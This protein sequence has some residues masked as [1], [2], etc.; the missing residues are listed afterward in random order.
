MS[1]KPVNLETLNDN[2]VGMEKLALALGGPVPHV[3]LVENFSVPCSSGPINVRCYKPNTDLPLPVLIYFHGGGYIRG[4]LDSHHDLCARLAAYGDFAVLSVDYRLAPENKFPAAIDDSIAVFKWVQSHGAEYGFMQDKIAVG[5]DSSGGCLAIVTA[6]EAK[7]QQLPL[8]VFQL[9]FYPTTTAYF[10][11]RSHKL[12]SKG[13]F[14]S[15]ERM[16]NYRDL[17][18]NSVAE[19]DDYRASPLLNPDLANLPSAL[20][21][22]A[23]FDPLRDEAEEYAKALGNC[24][25]PVGVIRYDGMVHGFVSLTAVLPAADKALRQAADALRH[26]FSA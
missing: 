9:L 16:E 10:D 8:P 17:Y 2:R 11:S 20:V 12:F 7:R 18:L 19:R 3:H 13:F 4:S 6:Q 5:G 15:T 14:L 24:E 21:I 25:V 1:S 23:G 22:T 26:C